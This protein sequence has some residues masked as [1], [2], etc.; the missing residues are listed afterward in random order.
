[1]HINNIPVELFVKILEYVPLKDAIKVMLVNREWYQ[2]Y[3]S[4][5]F[6]QFDNKFEE[7]LY[8]YWSDW[9]IPLQLVVYFNWHAFLI[10]KL[11]SFCKNFDRHCLDRRLQYVYDSLRIDMVDIDKERKVIDNLLIHYEA[12]PDFEGLFPEW[13]WEK[14]K[15]NR[16]ESGE[17]VRRKNLVYVLKRKI[18][19][20][21]WFTIH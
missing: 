15:N 1:M 17:N 13:L 6:K 12:S 14:H 4:I 11:E 3:R 19:E 2:E 16:W 18:R 5:I 8:S 10:D 9:N 7:L 21:F 20:H